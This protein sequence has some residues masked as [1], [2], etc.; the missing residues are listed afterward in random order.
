MTTRPAELKSLSDHEITDRLVEAYTVERHQAT[1]VV[2][3]LVEVE[4]RELHVEAGFA[5]LFAFC[6]DRLGMSV[7]VA[8]NRIY[9]VRVAAQYPDV[10]D[11]LADGRVYISGLRLLGPHLTRSNHRELL[12]A[13]SGKSKRDIEVLVAQRF[14]RPDEGPSIRKLPRSSRPA[15]QLALLRGVDSPTQRDG[16]DQGAD[17]ATSSAAAADN[18][19]PQDASPFGKITSVD[20]SASSTSTSTPPPVVAAPTGCASETGAETAPPAPE[21]RESHPLASPTTSQGPHKASPD[22]RHHEGTTPLSEDR[23]KVTFSAGKAVVAKLEHA[24][25]LLSH[26]IPGGDLEQIID[27]ALTA[28][29]ERVEKQRFGAPS[30]RKRRTTE[31]SAQQGLDNS[32]AEGPAT[33]TPEA[34]AGPTPETAR[35]VAGEPGDAS[36]EVDAVLGAG[37]K[38]PR[39]GSG[40]ERSRY[41]PA[42]VR[43]E[44]YER[45]GGCC[46]YQGPDGH[47]CAET[48]WLEFDHRHEWARGGPSTADNIRLRCRM[49]NAYAARR[50]YGRA[51]VRDKIWQAQRVRQ[52]RPAPGS[53]VPAV[54]REPG[55]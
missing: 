19:V 32:V 29:I 9:A 55:C 3:Y 28:L 26:A 12:D 24:K 16:S 50:S 1:D 25:A 20:A 14:P 33:T 36:G 18:S 10:L 15:P 34:S 51:H 35:T 30:S 45:D 31:A 5:S 13:A 41:I 39:D 22:N 17:G 48:R 46:T 49:H 38:S 37:T 6:V 11:M 23:Y 2:A 8:G 54:G 40:D 27:R 47:R 44:V 4:R 52:K 42:A 7:D 21:D 43:R 53:S